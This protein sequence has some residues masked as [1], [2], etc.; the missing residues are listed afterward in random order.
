MSLA[1]ML[2]AGMDRP[3]DSPGSTP[4]GCC[5]YFHRAFRSR[6]GQAAGRRQEA[7]R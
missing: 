2:V 7:F 5:S 3:A 6:F 1:D 4:T